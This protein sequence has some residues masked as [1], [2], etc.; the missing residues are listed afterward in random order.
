MIIDR[1]TPANKSH[2]FI[3]NQFDTELMEHRIP[4]TVFY[5]GF[6]NPDH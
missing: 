2:Y 5:C 4:T 6:C 1:N 3:Q